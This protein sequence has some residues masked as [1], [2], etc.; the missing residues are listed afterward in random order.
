MKKIAPKLQFYGI[1]HTYN[2]KIHSL[3]DDDNPKRK[4]K[5]AGKTKPGVCRVAVFKRVVRDLL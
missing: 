5:Y 2:N 4:I 3:S 1:F